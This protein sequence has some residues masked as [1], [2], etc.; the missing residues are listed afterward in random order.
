MADS[1]SLRASDAL[2]NF[3]SSA[4]NFS[5]F[6]A[7]R[8]AQRLKEAGAIDDFEVKP[9]RTM[10]LMSKSGSPDEPHISSAYLEGR[11]LILTTGFLAFYGYGSLLPEFLSRR[12]IQ[13]RAEDN[14]DILSLLAFINNQIHKRVFDS[15]LIRYPVI[16]EVE[17]NKNEI[18]KTQ[19]FRFAQQ[20]LPSN[21]KEEFEE[22]LP[23]L[24]PLF[25]VQHR[26]AYGVQKLL[27][28]V[29]QISNP[30]LVEADI[31]SV[32]VPRAS[33]PKVG[34]QAGFRLGDNA[35]IGNV[36]KNGSGNLSIQIFNIDIDL[37]TRLVHNEQYLK[38]L[39]HLICFYLKRPLM[40]TL[41][42]SLPI[43]IDL[44]IRLGSRQWNQLSRVGVTHSEDRGQRI[45]I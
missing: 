41:V 21:L 1:N 4:G 3:L 39:K 16:A 11:R 42:F 38:N 2:E 12:L 35:L 15:L 26:S 29:L 25:L 37:A 8:N 28:I 32:I 9:S 5:Y 33:R 24:A 40:V 45:E 43:E 22:F 6:Q 20:T 34:D 36:V 19:L 7:V 44:S 18:K 27:S 30:E 17:F 14:P 10:A 31:R 13:M 23:E